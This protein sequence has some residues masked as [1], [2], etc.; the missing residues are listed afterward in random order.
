M[1]PKSYYIWK[2][3]MARC[4]NKNA[5]RYADYGGRGIAVCDRW[6]SFDNFF[7]DMGEKPEWLSLERGDNNGNYCPENVQWKTAKAQANNRRSNVLL[8]YKGETKTM[9]Q[10]CD[11]IGL[12]IGT[13]WARINVYGYSVERALTPGWRAR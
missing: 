5:E 10:W 3:M 1:K 9:Q 6:H 2:S 8:T 7:A 11:E 13:V 12:R 4:Y